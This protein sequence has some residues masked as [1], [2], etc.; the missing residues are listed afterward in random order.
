[1]EN[2]TLFAWQQKALNECAD[3]MSYGLFADPGTG[4]T[5]CALR[6]A[7][8]WTYFA[9]VVCPSSVKKQWIQEAQQL[10]MP[11]HVYHY[12]Q[13][14][15]KDTFKELADTLRKGTGTFILDES[16]RIKSPS[17]LTTKLALKLAPLAINRLVLTGTPTA[18]S[19]ADL[20]CQFKFLEPERKM[21][22]YRDF[23]HRYIEALPDNH[24]I[25]KRIA[26]RPFIPK[27]DRFGM[28]VTKNLD[29]LRKR[30]ASYGITVKLEEVLE[31]PER[32]FVQ[33]LCAPEKDLLKT[34][35]ELEKNY[36]AQFKTKEVT[37]DNAAVLVG[38]LT[39]LT[40]GY[41]HADFDVSFRNPKLTELLCDM[42]AYV[43][44]GKCIVWSVWTAER[45][46]AFD[47]LSQAGY[48][49]TVDPYEF[50]EGDH[51]IL[52]SSPKMHGT[53][54]NLQLAKYQVWL[55]R[56]WSLLERE[57]ALARNYRAGQQQ[58]TIVVDYLTEGTIDQRVLQAL[59]NKNNLL[60]EIMKTG[61][62]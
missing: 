48:S 61:V 42:P 6:I 49:V 38:R 26:G 7:Q 14:R 20:Y 18:N 44:A 32:S 58:K 34:Y 12:E 45:N 47:A 19:P 16:H 2:R 52:L 35:R 5:Y 9:V 51:Q 29:Q 30:V 57:Q 41:G 4:K 17:T 43:A 50:M 33:R 60:N 22:S 11:V 23:Q 1:M 8:T 40:S 62:I 46:D 54:L 15:N 31:L 28:L 36:T 55:S 37:A 21:E 39:R 27:K 10:C 56:S 24:P 3:R 53:G 13:L 59:E 25:M